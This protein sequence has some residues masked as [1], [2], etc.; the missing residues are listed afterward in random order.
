MEKKYAEIT[1]K[2][3]GEFIS[4]FR[5]KAGMLGNERIH[6]VRRPPPVNVN[7][8]ADGKYRGSELVWVT[9]VLSAGGQ[10]AG[11]KSP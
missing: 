9:G 2:E 8:C 10:S 6:S 11:A 7:V 1:G 5:V 3:R 4:P